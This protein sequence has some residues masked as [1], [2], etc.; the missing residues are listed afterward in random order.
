MSAKIVDILTNHIME[1]K[2][3][4]FYLAILAIILLI[5]FKKKEWLEKLYKHRFLTAFVVFG[6]T[7]ILEISGSSIGIWNEFFGSTTNIDDG[8]VLGQSQGIRSDEWATFTIFNFAQKYNVSGAFEY[9]SESIRA[10]KTDLF[11]EY[12]G[13]VLN[14]GIIYI[15]YF[16]L[17]I[18]Y[19]EIQED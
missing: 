14:I 17:D 13:P 1:I 15:E 5:S 7:V 3:I 9:F 8:V 11:L 2:Y 10:T 6:I 16:K 18:F 19:L 12:G 4:L